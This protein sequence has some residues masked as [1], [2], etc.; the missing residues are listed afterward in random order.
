M[1]WPQGGA[2]PPNGPVG[3]RLGVAFGELPGRG[4]PVK[5]VQNEGQI[6][7]FGSREIAKVVQK[8]PLSF[9]A[10]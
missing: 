3:E 2:W 9:A 8:V 5:Q 4:F 7:Q 1:R 10:L 6:S